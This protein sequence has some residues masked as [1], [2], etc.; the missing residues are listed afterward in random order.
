[1]STDNIEDIYPLSPMQEGILF[2]TLYAPETGMYV[3]QEACTF[4]GLDIDAFIRSWEKVIDRHAIL[5]TAFAWKRLKRPVQVVGRSVGLPVEREDWRGLPEWEQA[6]RFDD[7]LVAD[8]N[9]NF[10]LSKAPLMRMAF[11]QVSDDSYRFVWS[12]HHLLLDGWSKYLLL[13]EVLAY[14]KAFSRGETCSLDQPRPYKD[15]IAWLQKQD[16]SKAEEFWLEALKDFRRTTTIRGDVE[17]GREIDVE[18][19]YGQQVLVLSAEETDWLQSFARQKR[20]TFNTLVQAAWALLLNRYSGERDIVFGTT[21]SGRPAELEGV[22]SMIGLFINTLPV[23]VQIREHEPVIAWLKRL[24]SY[25]VA[26]RQFEHTPLVDVRRWSEIP[27]GLNLFDSLVVF[28]N[29]PIDDS[30]RDAERVLASEDSPVVER[31]NFPIV[32]VAAPSPLLQMKVLYDRRIFTDEAIDRI[33]NNLRDALAQMTANPEGT[34]ADIVLNESESLLAMNAQS[35]GDE[36]E[37]F[38]F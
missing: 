15:Y 12:S 26:I 3:L 7:Y 30:L 28:Q 36:L 5:R 34:V 19:S 20:L 29:F 27:P 14:Y 35:L 18:D 31:N 8:R 25:Q 13:K 24:Q 22:E 6:K 4:T 1:M 11:F 2:H 32:L 9:R 23:R 37:Q 10:N 16:L 38:S 21:L 33:L 17:D